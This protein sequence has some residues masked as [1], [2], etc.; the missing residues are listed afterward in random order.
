MPV[1]VIA[2]PLSWVLL[3][4]GSSWLI[5]RYRLLGM[6]VSILTGWGI[7]VLV[8]SMWPAPPMPYDF[9]EDR[10]EMP[11][12]GTFIMGTWCVPVYCISDV[13]RRQ[14][15]WLAERGKISDV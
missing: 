5:A 15:Q 3:M 1:C 4:G 11:V 14:K 8:Y 12:M 2:R 13:W 10:E 7:L 9:D 6:I